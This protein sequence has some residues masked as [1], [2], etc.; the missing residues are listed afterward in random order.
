LERSKK[1]LLLQQQVADG[2]AALR[3]KVKQV[4]DI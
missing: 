1:P 4:D 2:P 3:Q